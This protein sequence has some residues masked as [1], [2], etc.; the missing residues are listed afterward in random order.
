ML[1]N[2]LGIIGLF[3]LM[4]LAK[5]VWKV[6]IGEPFEAFLRGVLWQ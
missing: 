5:S 2:I 4:M 1:F 3:A 6:G